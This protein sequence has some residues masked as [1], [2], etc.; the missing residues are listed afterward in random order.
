MRLEVINGMLHQQL[1][2]INPPTDLD[3]APHECIVFN[4]GQRTAGCERDEFRE[5]VS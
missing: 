2:F 3:V 4:T 5:F 1:I